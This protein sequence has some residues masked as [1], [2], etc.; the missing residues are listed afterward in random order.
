MT[1][2][3]DILKNASIFVNYPLKNSAKIYVCYTCTKCH[4][5]TTELSNK[6]AQKM[7]TLHYIFFESI[8]SAQ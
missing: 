6:N 5:V 1:F 8:C 4:N 7:I 2:Y 3:F